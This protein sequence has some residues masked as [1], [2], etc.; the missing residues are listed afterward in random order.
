MKYVILVLII[1]AF[2][3]PAGAIIHANTEGNYRI[4][5]STIPAQPVIN[6]PTH[7]ELHVQNTATGATVGGL[8]VNDL[9]V[10]LEEHVGTEPHVPEENLTE[11]H[12]DIFHRALL[13]MKS[14]PNEPP[15]HY[16]VN[17]TFD[18]IGLYEIIVQFDKNGDRVAT[19]F[20]LDVKSGSGEEERE[21]LKLR[22]SLFT[23]IGASV[24][25]IAA[26]V[27]AFRRIVEILNLR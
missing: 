10:H 9:V 27:Y 2:I 4:I 6:V 23:I 5:L 16:H 25:V 15:G 26:A 18:E 1:I 14:E 22:Y 19:V 24:A 7:L 21:P 3:A 20:P 11:I 8:E 13:R 12:S 17:Y